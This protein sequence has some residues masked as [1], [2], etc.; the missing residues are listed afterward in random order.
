MATTGVSRASGGHTATDVAT[1]ADVHQLPNIAV[2]VPPV[3][4]AVPPK[5]QTLPPL[6]R[7]SHCRR[8]LLPPLPRP[9]CPRPAA[10]VLT[11]SP[12]PLT[13][14]S[15]CGVWRVVGFVRHRCNRQRIA[16]DPSARVTMVT[17]AI[18]IIIIT[19]IINFI[20]VVIIVMVST[21]HQYGQH[22]HHHDAD[23]PDHHQLDSM[24]RQRRL[25]NV[26][27]VIVRAHHSIVGFKV[28]LELDR[29]R[30]CQLAQ[31]A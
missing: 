15:Y 13:S 3:C 9:L 20:V 26:T 27:I 2:F 29:G 1:T 6:Q 31:G 19:M 21:V 7:Q 8:Y 23:Y 17:M 10:P 5:A 22:C 12:P 24:L 18:I 11:P 30:R 4:C 28:L 25:M 16:R 14:A